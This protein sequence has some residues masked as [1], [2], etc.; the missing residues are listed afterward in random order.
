M[1]VLDKTLY[2]NDCICNCCED[3]C[4]IFHGHKTGVQVFRPSPFMPQVDE[5]TCDTCK[6]CAEA[7]PVGE[8]DVDD[9]AYVD[10]DVCLGCGVCVPTCKPQSIKLVRRPKVEEKAATA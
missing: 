8:I 3:C 2:I 4:A 6:A 7:C 1:V 10:Q 9:S 5:E